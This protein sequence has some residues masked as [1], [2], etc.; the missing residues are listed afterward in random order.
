MSDEMEA[1]TGEAGKKPIDSVEAV[2]EILNR[3]ADAASVEAVYQKPIEHGDHLIIPAAEITAMTG[4]GFGSGEGSGES[5]EKGGGSG[6]GGGGRIFSRPV[7]VIVSSPGGVEVQPVF[8][9]TKIALAGMTTGVLMIGAFARMLS[10]RRKVE[11]V[12]SE[13]MKGG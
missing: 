9:L 11:R 6:G 5:G 7:A 3:L 10:L 2:Q 4:F 13:L 8:D 12:H 1:R